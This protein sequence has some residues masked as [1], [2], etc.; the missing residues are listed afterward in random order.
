MAAGATAQIS[1]QARRHNDIRRKIVKRNAGVRAL[2]GANPWTA[3]AVPIL[4]GLHW[5]MAWLVSGSNLLVCFL[6][7]F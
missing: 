6:A 7:A 1:P 2:A 3:L 4:L 5:G